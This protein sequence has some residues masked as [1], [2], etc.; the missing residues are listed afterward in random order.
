ME[1]AELNDKDSSNP[2][3]G[4]YIGEIRYDHEIGKVSHKVKY[5]WNPCPL[6]KE[7]KWS[8]IRKDAI[9]YPHC[10]KCGYIIAKNK[11]RG[12]IKKKRVTHNNPPVIG[13][14]RFG[15]EVGRKHSTRVLWH[16]CSICGKER[17]VLLIHGKPQNTKCTICGKLGTIRKPSFEKERECRKC[18]KIYP[19]TREF[20]SP[21][22]HSHL[23]I[24][25]TCKECRKV[26]QAKR[27][28]EK[29]L[30]GRFKLHANMSAAVRMALLEKKGGRQWEKLVGYTCEE[31]AEH[32]EKQFLIGMT[33]DNYGLKG[34]TI[35]HIIPVSAFNFTSANDMDFHR[36]WALS[37]LQPMWHPDNME[38][39]MKVDKPFQPSLALGIKEK[40]AVYT[41]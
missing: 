29:R 3:V 21:T 1:E 10:I 18:H 26:Q 9:L 19:T 4:S 31:L 16:S 25:R 40:Q 37:N 7:P 24:S 36:C 34:W 14:I 15:D 23:G 12:M 17:W 20:F 6:C 27:M 38:K 28:R 33:W 41:A 13:E 8:K 39:R 11:H 2:I 5:I 32:L 35:D 22:T 30:D